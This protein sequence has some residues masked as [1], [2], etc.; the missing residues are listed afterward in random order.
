MAKPW[1]ATP[2]KPYKRYKTERELKEHNKKKRKFDENWDRIFGDRE[3]PNIVKED[4]DKHRK[5]IQD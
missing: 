2:G 4:D 1:D 3:I 5:D